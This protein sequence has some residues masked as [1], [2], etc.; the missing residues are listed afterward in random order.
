VL[1]LLLACAEAPESACP[2]WSG[3][4]LEGRAWTYSPFGS[5]DDWDEVATPTGVDRFLLERPGYE[6]D[7][8]CTEAGL[9]VRSEHR[10]TDTFEAW[11]TYEPPALW[12]PATLES[13]T[14]WSAGAGYT[15]HDSD[16]VTETRSLDT[17]FAVVGASE[18]YV[19]AGGFDTLVVQVQ[20]GLDVGT[21][22]YADGVGLVLDDDVQL[23][24]VR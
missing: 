19:T 6:A 24:E 1:L 17:Q 23:V 7:V 4:T 14:V 16:G 22:Y 2:A 15:Y 11:W 21:R 18:Q 20:D 10:S 13:G 3:L 12:M 8:A 9:E 5:T